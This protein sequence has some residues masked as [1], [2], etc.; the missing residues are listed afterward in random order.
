SF[1]GSRAQLLLE[2]NGLVNGKKLQKYLSLKNGTGE[3]LTFH[4]SSRTSRIHKINIADTDKSKFIVLNIEKQLSSPQ[5]DRGMKE[6]FQH[7]LALDKKIDFNYLSCTSNGDS[8]KL[9]LKLSRHVSVENLKKHLH[10]SPPID[11]TLK[12]Y[13][14]LRYQLHGEFQPLTQYTVTVDK[15]LKSQDGS[16]LDKSIHKKVLTGDF[17]S[18]IKFLGKGPILPAGRDFK[19]A[20]RLTNI[21]ELDVK[22]TRIFPNNLVNFYR[23]RSYSLDESG[24]EVFSRTIKTKLKHNEPGNVYLDINSAIKMQ[25]GIFVISAK[26]KHQWHRKKRIIIR[27]NIGL[28]MAR[29]KEQL[30][31]WSCNINNGKSLANCQVSLFS[32][33][34]QLL[35]SILT[36]EQGFGEFDLS[37]LKDKPYL[38]VLK[39]GKDRLFRNLKDTISLSSFALPSRPFNDKTYEAYIFA[40]R[41]VCRPGEKIDLTFILRD[42]VKRGDGGF[43]LELLIKGPSGSPFLRKSILV[44][45]DGFFSKLINIPAQAR[46]GYYSV[47]LQI[48]GPKPLIL[49]KY[50]FLVNLFT[51]DTFKVNLTAEDKII[52]KHTAK[53]SLEANYN[54][55]SPLPGAKANIS[56]SFRNAS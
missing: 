38:I 42:Q 36:D 15:G 12:K 6:D 48:P 54:F 25:Q 27:T 30:Q 33:N 50:H 9:E 23:N 32:F 41:D 22:I 1:N 18:S 2:F 37:D 43:P 14:G 17:G 39:K 21:D 44:P 13:Y 31:I 47:F 51:P 49:G 55:G 45:E 34:N 5:A 40:E 52:R 53:I 28:S 56:Y 46:T 24:Q 29:S 10:L 20:M 35:K 11:F 4:T 8:I 26:N 16:T 7:K 3:S 19:V